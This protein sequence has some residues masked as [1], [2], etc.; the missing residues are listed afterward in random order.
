MLD[1]DIYFKEKL[2]CFFGFVYIHYFD[3]N[4]LS[5]FNPKYISVSVMSVELWEGW[6]WSQGRKTAAEHTQNMRPAGFLPSYM[7]FNYFSTFSWEFSLYPA[8]PP[9]SRLL[10]FYICH[11][12]SNSARI[13]S[14]FTYQYAS[15]SFWKKK[16]LRWEFLQPYLDIPTITI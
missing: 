8:S 6:R 2:K 4:C 3:E 9:L 13:F 5:C 16:G 15:N 1:W 10:L 11:S 7:T 12:S 14:S